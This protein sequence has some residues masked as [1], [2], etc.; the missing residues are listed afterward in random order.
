MV[1]EG[2]F[3]AAAD[4][5]LRDCFRN[6]RPPHVSELAKKIGLSLSQF[7]YAFVAR[8]GERPGAYIKRA[9][10]RRAKFL[11]RTTSLPTTQVGYRAGYGT[12]MSFFRGFKRATGMTPTE[13]RESLARGRKGKEAAVGGEDAG[14]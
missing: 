14:E 9:Q 7:S 10:V 11:L 6:R 8:H 2:S 1:E 3:T 12:R 13:Y 4:S 5:Y